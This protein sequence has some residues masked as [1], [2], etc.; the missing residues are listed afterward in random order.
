MKDQN[1]T[2]HKRYLIGYHVITFALIFILT[3]ASVYS[4]YKSY[5]THYN[6]RESL[7]FLITSL[8]LFSVY[9]Y[10]RIFALK[11][12]DR[13]IHAEESLRYFVMTGKLPDSSLKMSQFLALRF[14]PDDEFLELAKKA[15]EEN[16]SSEDIKK[17]IKNWKADN[18]RV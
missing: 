2:N 3:A 17:S 6:I 11:A 12:Q 7:M 8:I 14:A 16:L 9:L 4:V 10:C 5:N 13:A 1:Y 15:V 18:Y